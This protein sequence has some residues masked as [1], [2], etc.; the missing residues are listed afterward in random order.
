M[1]D[2]DRLFA[3]LDGLGGERII[4][5][6]L[7]RL[8]LH[9]A[10][11]AVTQGVLRDMG[12]PEEL[13]CPKCDSELRLKVLS[14]SGSYCI[15]CPFCPPQQ[16]DRK[17]VTAL[18]PDLEQLQSL[19]RRA[20]DLRAGKSNAYADG[21]VVELGLV[22]KGTKGRDWMSVVGWKL[23]REARLSAAMDTLGRQ[24][25]RGPGL[26]IAA[27]PLSFAVPLPK[28]YRLARPSDVW[29]IEQGDL[30]ANYE[31]IAARMGWPN[32]KPRRRGGRRNR[33]DDVAGAIAHFQRGGNW[34][35]AL[36][37]QRE[38]L[39]EHWPKGFGNVPSRS[40]LYAKLDE[41]RDASVESEN[42]ACPD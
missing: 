31:G 7:T 24:V 17:T 37:A 3:F 36:A 33:R 12:V 27:E 32:Q 21:S 29:R 25:R 6:Q 34:P 14:R 18:E 35:E 26:F 28:R 41:L 20:L 10:D 15:P 40:T 5:H 23:R 42:P 19:C 39:Q 1:D 30:V 2:L 38:L 11:W 4:G 13:S 16:F 22:T 9:L 8:N